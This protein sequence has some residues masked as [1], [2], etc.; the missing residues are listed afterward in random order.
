M[1]TDKQIL[2]LIVEEIDEYAIEV[3]E[4]YHSER[5]RIG[6]WQTVKMNKLQIL[7]A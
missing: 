7:I 2:D 1:G 4:M 3:F 6:F 5:S